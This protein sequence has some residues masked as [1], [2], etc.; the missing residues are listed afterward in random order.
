MLVKS[1]IGESAPGAT[2]R[3]KVAESM[4][5]IATITGFTTGAETLTAGKIDMTL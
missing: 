4:D 5:V 3:K 1:D 2:S